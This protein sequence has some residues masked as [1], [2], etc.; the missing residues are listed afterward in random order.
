MISV[1]ILNLI[2]DSGF[3]LRTLHAAGKIYVS[4]L[5]PLS[6]SCWI[7]NRLV[8]EVM[9]ASSLI[10]KVTILNWAIHGEVTLFHQLHHFEDLSLLGIFYYDTRL[11]LISKWQVTMIT[12]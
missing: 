8:S 5:L 7:Q 1:L 9:S 12:F 6:L 3:F 10:R 11:T 4:F 2:S